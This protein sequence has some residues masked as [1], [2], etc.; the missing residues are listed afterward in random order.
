M[1]NVSSFGTQTDNA[2][3]SGTV[4]DRQMIIP[5][6]PPQGLMS[7]GPRV[8]P[9]FVKPRE[10]NA[11]TT[12]HFFDA[13]RDTA[14]NAYIA[15]KPVV[16]AG[17]PLTDEDYWFLWAD[18]DTRFDDLN[19]TVKTF[20]QRITQN[21]ND[22]ATKA[23][24]NHA[25][26][27]TVYGVGNSL[28]YGHLKLATTDT[29]MTSD[30]NAGIAATPKTVQDAITKNI[31]TP[32]MFGAVGDGIHDDSEAIN[33][34]ISFIS[35]K[36]ATFD[37]T[38]GV[39]GG[40]L[41]LQ[42]KHYLCRTPIV[43]KT[44][45]YLYDGGNNVCGITIEGAG[46]SA[47]IIDYQGSGN[48]IECK[49]CFVVLKNFSVNGGDIGIKVNERSPYFL[50][51]NIY[52]KRC[53]VCGIELSNNTYMS[54]LI[55]C[56]VS[57]CPTGFNCP[58]LHTS[59]TFMNCYA[60]DC[61]NYGY[62]LKGEKST[63]G[64]LYSSLISCGADD[65]GTAYYIGD[66]SRGFSL[67]SC[68]SERSKSA[69]IRIKQ[70]AYVNVQSYLS[71]NN[72]GK[73]VL[74]EGS[75]NTAIVNNFNVI[76]NS[77][78]NANPIFYTDA[79]NNH[80]QID[81]NYYENNLGYGGISF[82]V[83]SRTSYKTV[84]AV[85]GVCDLGDIKNI[86]TGSDYVSGRVEITA[87]YGKYLYSDSNQANYIESIT[88]VTNTYTAI[89]ELGS[90]IVPNNATASACKFTFSISNGHLI[91]THALTDGNTNIYTFIL[92]TSGNIKII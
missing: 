74:F 46:K 2:T 85:N 54:T 17:T 50:F 28:N 73:F 43:L 65:C 61:E 48:A 81:R 26:E 55:N 8:T 22:I 52:V 76:L 86:V 68:G 36:S 24:I 9:N 90:T 15:T 23:P 33:N 4:T 40:K 19:E 18:P 12:Y 62:Y 89:K 3:V 16:P 5:D 31:V 92:K 83:Q 70:Y 69:D 27:D 30:S 34:A 88:K 14:G 66:Y 38:T 6:I 78:S 60:N 58:G 84:A 79:I 53:N 10:W 51:E 75:N 63:E 64:F 49:G 1:P 29:P 91:A 72:N 37:P 32:E 77:V 59:V 47:S 39:Q 45:G 20:N 11:Q 35:K 57:M 41:T 56:T 7:V 71:V 67:I 80:V 87:I 13:V 44:N 25:S 82:D 21:T 42:N